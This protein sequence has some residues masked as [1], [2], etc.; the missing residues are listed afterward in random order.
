MFNTIWDNFKLKLDL[1][2]KIIPNKFFVSMQHIYRKIWET[3]LVVA[4]LYVIIFF[5]FTLKSVLNSPDFQ[6]I[7]SKWVK[8]SSKK[9]VSLIKYTSYNLYRKSLAAFILNQFYRSV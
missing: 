7:V 2:L 5:V 3:L 9:Y 6:L 1:I 4:L 8:S